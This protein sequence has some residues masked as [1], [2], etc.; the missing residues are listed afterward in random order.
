MRKGSGRSFAAWLELYSMPE[1]NSGC[2]LWMGSV[3]KTGYGQIIVQKKSFL[4]HRIAYQ[5][6]RGPIPVGSHV[7][8]KCDVRCCVNPDHLW[9]GTNAENMADKARKG[10]AA[11]GEGNAAS[12]LTEEQARAIIAAVGS[13]RA[14]AKQFGVCQQTVCKIKTGKYWS[15]L[16]A[17]AALEPPWQ[18][19]LDRI[20]EKKIL[21]VL[22][23]RKGKP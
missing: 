20:D 19:T 3:Q 22:G 23:K 5:V 1:P 8:H 12:K 10:R 14:I 15:H 2:I 21:R 16:R 7:L 13:Q 4:A 9:L 6:L 17:S 11:R 18:S